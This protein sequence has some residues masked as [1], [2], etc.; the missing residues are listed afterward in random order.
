MDERDVIFCRMRYE[1]DSE[2][3]NEYYQRNVEKKEKDDYLRSLPNIG[4][5]DNIWYDSLIHPFINS[6][7]KMITEMVA[8]DNEEVNDNKT[9]VDP[10]KTSIFIKEILFKMGARA[11]IIK[12]DDS[13]FYS[14]KGRPDDKYGD[15]IDKQY[16][17]IIIFSMPMD[18]EYINCAPLPPEMLATIMQYMQGSYLALWLS[19][20]INTLG[21][22]SKANFDGNYDMVLPLV[23]QA[24]GLGSI[25]YNGLLIDEFYGPRVRLGAVLTDLDL[26]ADEYKQFDFKRVCEQCNL[27]EDKCL[28]QAINHQA[29][30]IVEHEKCYERWRIYGTDCAVCLKVCPF[31]QELYQKY[32]D[33]LSNDQ[34]ITMFI[35][36]HK[37]NLS[38]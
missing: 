13:F 27:C 4:H 23:A 10:K 32:R 12:C 24:A 29:T 38:D 19:K 15:K 31:S 11:K 17:N 22:K 36:E 6:G 5:E 34:M 25:G 35:E 18:L 3:Y 28:A 9:K 20:Y 33:K 16:K 26:E 7:F 8:L 37:N 1:E 21:Y 14:H 30:P 2:N